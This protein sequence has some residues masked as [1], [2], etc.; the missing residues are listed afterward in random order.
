[1]S[2]P[3]V[4]QTQHL[5]R[6]SLLAVAL[7]RLGGVGGILGGLD[8]IPSAHAA[9]HAEGSSTS[10]QGH[11]SAVSPG[12]TTL[13]RIYLVAIGDNGKSGTRIGCG[14]SLVAVTRS[15]ARTTAPLSAAMRLL[16]SDHH[17]YYG[18]SEL[19]NA[20]YQSRLRLQ[21]A[22][23]VNGKAIIH[24]TGTMQLDGVCDDPRV[25]AQLR[26][27]ARQF[28]TVHRVAI[29]VN[30]VPLWKLLSGKGG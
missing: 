16:L 7:L 8:L 21:R 22:A 27:T 10:A 25:G 2:S 19:Y 20:L 17:R 6:T 9:L 1:M 28:P 11:L 12:K 15:I 26:Q 14:D 30:N 5:G 23:I 13:V 3:D 29:C 24:L 18:Q 4:S